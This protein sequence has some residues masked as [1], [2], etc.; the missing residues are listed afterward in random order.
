MSANVKTV[1]YESVD[2]LLGISKYNPPAA[3]AA[4][5]PPAAPAASQ[6]PQLECSCDNN[7]NTPRC[8]YCIDTNFGGWFR[9]FN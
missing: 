6:P 9:S 4:S 5:Q 2:F 7:I 1:K 3:P 8:Q